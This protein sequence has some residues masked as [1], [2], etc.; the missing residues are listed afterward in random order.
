MYTSG[1]TGVP[2]GVLL[3][4]INIVSTSTAIFYLK[5]FGP[6]DLYI[7][8]LPLAH[9]LEL[10]SELTMLLLG[11]PVGYSSPNTMTDMSSAIKRGEKG[12]ISLLK[13]TIMC[14]VP[15]VLVRIQKVSFWLKIAIDSINIIRILLMLLGRKV[16]HS[17]KSSTCFMSTSWS[18]IKMDTP[19]HFYQSLF[20]RSLVTCWVENW[21][22]CW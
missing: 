4:H 5:T 16:Q 9:V 12:D 11:V 22:S 3:S 15:L 20:S 10:T 21:V 18:G 14:S 7:A 19:L 1:S 13:P 17:K 8:Y 2:K 6:E